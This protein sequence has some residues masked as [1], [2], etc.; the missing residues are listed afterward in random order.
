MGG[1]WIVSP[2]GEELKRIPIAEQANNMTFGGTD[3][4]TLY[5]ACKDKVYSLDMMVH[6]GE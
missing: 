1:V 4:T 3:Y 5:I 2:T 6:G